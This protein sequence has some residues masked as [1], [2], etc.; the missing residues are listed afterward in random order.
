MAS[1]ESLMKKVEADVQALSDAIQADESEDQ[2]K[3]REDMADLH[4][5]F[6]AL[7]ASAEAIGEGRCGA[8][9]CGE[10]PRERGGARGFDR[11]RQRGYGS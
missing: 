1:V 3:I 4:K 8:A 11:R 2:S 5:Q 9:E 10:L 6:T 7:I